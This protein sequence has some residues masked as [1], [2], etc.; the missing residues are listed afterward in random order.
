[1]RS[2]VRVQMLSLV[3]FLCVGAALPVGAQEVPPS[4]RLNESFVVAGEADEKLFFRNQ[5][6][7]VSFEGYRWWRKPV[8]TP[9][10]W[11]LEVVLTARERQLDGL[12]A[13]STF[14]P[15]LSAGYIGFDD[16][17]GCLSFSENQRDVDCPTP[18]PFDETWLKYEAGIRYPAP[19]GDGFQPIVWQWNSQSGLN[20]L[21]AGIG[22]TTGSTEDGW[23]YGRTDLAAGL[24]L[25]PN[26]GPAIK[27]SEDFE[28]ELPLTVR[29][30]AG[31]FNTGGIELK[32][33]KGRTAVRLT[34]IV[35]PDLFESVYLVDRSVDDASCLGGALVRI[36]GG[37]LTCLPGQG[38]DWYYSLLP[39]PDE[40]S[41]LLR[42]FVVNGNAPEELS[43]LDGDGDV[44]SADA[45]LAGFRIISNEARFVVRQIRTEASP[46]L[47][48]ASPYSTY[49]FDFDGNGDP[50]RF[51]DFPG[52]ALKVRLP[53]R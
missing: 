15:Y 1:M 6:L 3:R 27:V 30:L 43:D 51:I 5:E 46:P 50:G 21:L 29:N 47:S 28:R 10:G 13:E 45:I 19:D 36:D 49:P 4:D 48:N 52:L 31:F 7:H 2:L 44:D 37:P 23:G 35:P 11:P 16:P 41:V 38:F 39:R 9:G 34:M 42:A 40:E 20:D 17:D 25:L 24:L 8:Q 26:R 22:P 33:S 18:W 53:P 14:F 12:A 32:N